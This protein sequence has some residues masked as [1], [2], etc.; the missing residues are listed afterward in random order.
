LSELHQKE[1]DKMVNDKI[2]WK[3]CH[4]GGVCKP[5]SLG[6]GSWISCFTDGRIILACLEQGYGCQVMKALVDKFG[7][8]YFENK[9]GVDFMPLD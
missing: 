4:D 1:R 9:K 2:V 6:C 8:S 5:C 7:L 3:S